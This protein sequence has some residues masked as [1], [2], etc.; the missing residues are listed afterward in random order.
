MCIFR[1]TC[2]KS[3]SV[4]QCVTS[5]AY[6]YLTFTYR[7]QI[8]ERQRLHCRPHSDHDNKISLD[9]PDVHLQYAMYYPVKPLTVLLVNYHFHGAMKLL[10][11]DHQLTVN[12]LK[13]AIY[14]GTLQNEICVSICASVCVRA[15]FFMVLSV[16][17]Y[18]V[19]LFR[20]RLRMIRRSQMHTKMIF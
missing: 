5:H 18:S 1:L 12:H 4:T 13:C 10:V 7:T 15:S 9:L 3:F 2:G 8:I 20:C 16:L 19:L 14:I 6:Q 11:P 17:F